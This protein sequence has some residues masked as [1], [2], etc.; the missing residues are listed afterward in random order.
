MLST[1]PKVHLLEVRH[2]PPKHVLSIH[3]FYLCRVPKR[4][5]ITTQ[6]GSQHFSCS[7]HN[8][9]ERPVFC[10]SM[11]TPDVILPQRQSPHTRECLP[12]RHATYVL[13]QVRMNKQ[14]LRMFRVGGVGMLGPRRPDSVLQHCC[15]A[16]EVL[17][18][19]GDAAAEQ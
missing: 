2:H 18:A 14:W 12:P 7:T 17:I 15:A 8:I 4:P 5:N 1:V 9:I 6:T 11:P 13:E 10:M 16:E 19:I 3:R